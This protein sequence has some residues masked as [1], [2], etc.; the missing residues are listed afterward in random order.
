MSLGLNTPVA[1]A[2]CGFLNEVSLW[3]YTNPPT[4][5]KSVPAFQQS[6][7]EHKYLG[8]THERTEEYPF[9][10]PLR[11]GNGDIRFRPSNI[12]RRSEESGYRT[13]STTDDLVNKV[14]ELEVGVVSI[15]QTTSGGRAVTEPMVDYVNGGIDQMVNDASRERKVNEAEEPCLR[16]GGIHNS[17]EVEGTEE[18]Q[19]DP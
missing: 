5:S 13:L 12:Y 1:S 10:G 16:G 4:R 9:E 3:Y 18:G 11:F 17:R 6:V 8:S 15:G 14:S 7:T 19:W 2:H